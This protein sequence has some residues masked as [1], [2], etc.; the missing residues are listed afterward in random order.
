MEILCLMF[1]LILKTIHSTTCTT[2]APFIKKIISYLIPRKP[3]LGDRAFTLVVPEDVPAGFAAIFGF[4]PRIF[5]AND[6]RFGFGFRLGN[7]ADFQVLYEFGPQTVTKPLQPVS[8]TRSL[9]YREQL[10]K[11]RPILD[12]LLRIGILQDSSYKYDIIHNN[13]VN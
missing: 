6:H 13:G 5:K 1:I 10:T 9:N 3:F 7:H 2:L 4:S 12:F 11:R 8:R